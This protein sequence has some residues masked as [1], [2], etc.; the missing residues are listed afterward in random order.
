[1][2]EKEI[3]ESTENELM[4]VA[5]EFKKMKTEHLQLLFKEHIALRD[6]GDE[7]YL[8]LKE[9][10]EFKSIERDFRSI[11][12]EFMNGKKVKYKIEFCS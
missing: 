3:L 1:M 5:A 12:V 9:N 11:T 4:A 6:L 2:E 7:L 8:M 10:Y